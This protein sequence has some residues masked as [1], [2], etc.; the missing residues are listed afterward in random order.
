[1]LSDIVDLPTAQ[2]LVGTKRSATYGTCING[3]VK[4]VIHNTERVSYLLL[5]PSPSSHPQ[6]RRLVRRENI[7]LHIQTTAVQL[8]QVLAAVHP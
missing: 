8:W 5:V 2:V 6:S 1:M 7:R 4:H 3:P